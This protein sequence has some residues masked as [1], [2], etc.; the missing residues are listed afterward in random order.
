[1]VHLTSR[2]ASSALR[3]PLLRAPCRGLKGFSGSIGGNLKIEGPRVGSFANCEHSFEQEDVNLFAQ[4]CGDSNPLHSDPEF[5]KTT[6]FGGTI[7]HGILVSS[8]FSTLFGASLHGAVYV[9]QTLSFQRPVHVGTLVTAKMTI[10]GKSQRRSGHEL[11]CD[12]V[13]TLPNGKVAVK[14]TAICL[15]PYPKEEE[16]AVP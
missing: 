5:A 7:V 4:I 11:V 15:L 10:T 14:G 3:A 1:M 8:L 6:M 12:T 16:A 13:V 2:L 9:N